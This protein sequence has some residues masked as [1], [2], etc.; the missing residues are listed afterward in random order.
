LE[1]HIGFHEIYAIVIDEDQVE[2]SI[3]IILQ[4]YCLP[5]DTPEGYIIS[6]DPPMPFIEEIDNIGKVLVNF[7][8][9]MKK[10]DLITQSKY[11]LTTPLERKL[12]SARVIG[13]R[14]TTFEDFA[15]INNGTI[16]V[17]STSV[18]TVEVSIEREGQSVDLNFTWSL[19]NFTAT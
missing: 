13:D 10:P 17:N 18:P 1:E 12:S 5:E 19:L 8:R 16:S 11:T 4:I 15:Y 7:G 3:T 9:F 14:L 6:L 2:S